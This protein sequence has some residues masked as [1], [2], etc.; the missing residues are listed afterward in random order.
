MIPEFIQW[1]IVGAT[2]GAAVFFLWRIL[3][4]GSSACSGCAL[5][6]ACKRKGQKGGK[7]CPPQ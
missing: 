6:D 1:I 7:D 2:V 3:R 4:S 5:K